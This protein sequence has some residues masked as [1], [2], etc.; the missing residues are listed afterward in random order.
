MK[1]AAF[2]LVCL[3]TATGFAQQ[4]VPEIQFD[5]NPDFFKLPDDLHF[6]ETAGVA[7]NSQGQVYVFSRGNTIGPA[8]GATASQVLQFDKN[9]KFMR[10]VGKGL[11]AWAFAHTVRVDRQDNLWAVDKGSDMIIKFNPQGRVMMVLV[12]RPKH[13]TKMRI[14]GSIPIR[15]VP[16]RTAGSA[17]LRTSP[18]IPKATSSSATDTSTPGWPSS[19][20]MATG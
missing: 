8:Y 20:R 19:T 3:L 5:S 10:E 6:G 9:G 12:A 7:V 11:Y 17:S 1:K 14:P 16:R 18:G 4:A 13:L 15:R 2:A